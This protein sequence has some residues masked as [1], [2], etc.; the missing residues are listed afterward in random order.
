MQARP[1]I[2]NCGSITIANHHLST[3]LKIELKVMFQRMYVD[4]VCP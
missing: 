4:Q 2:G 3:L 1:E